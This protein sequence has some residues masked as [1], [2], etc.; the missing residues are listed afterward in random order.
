[1]RKDTYFCNTIHIQRIERIGVVGIRTGTKINRVWRLWRWSTEG[2]PAVDVK[3]V[4]LKKLVILYGFCFACEKFTEFFQEHIFGKKFLLKCKS[5]WV[6]SKQKK[7]KYISS[8]IYWWYTYEKLYQAIIHLILETKT[9][10]VKKST[11]IIMKSVCHDVWQTLAASTLQSCRV[12][13]HFLRE[14]KRMLHDYV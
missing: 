12:M 7:G 3:R 4:T 9:R 13:T 8:L 1:M 14:E 2:T 5:C 10:Q 11:F 6:F